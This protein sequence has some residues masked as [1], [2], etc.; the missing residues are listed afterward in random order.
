MVV[1]PD[2]VDHR[3][4]QAP[5]LGEPATGAG[6]VDAQHLLLDVRDRSTFGTGDLHDPA[7]ALGQATLQGHLADVVHQATDEGFLRLNLVAQLPFR[8]PPIRAAERAVNW[9]LSADMAHVH[10][11][12]AVI[13]VALLV[14][15]L[16]APWRK[17]VVS[18]KRE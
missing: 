13:H 11:L 8:F 17:G 12:L 9:M 4:R 2:A 18:P 14:V 3:F 1:Q 5:A 7:E 6:V 16:F 15:I 10:T